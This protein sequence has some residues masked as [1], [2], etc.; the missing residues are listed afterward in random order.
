MLKPVT[1]ND[2]GN[3]WPQQSV[4]NDNNATGSSTGSAQPST[5]LGEPDRASI[6]LEAPLQTV[7]N[8]FL[9]SPQILS[10]STP[11]TG[12]SSPPS[13]N[14]EAMLATV[15]QDGLK[16]MSASK[17]LQGDRDLVL[18]AVRQNGLALQ[19]ASKELQS[20]KY[21]VLAAV[22]QN[23]S[24]LRHASRELQDDR[25]FNLSVVKQDGLALESVN[26]V[27]QNDREF[28]LIALQQNGLSL[29]FA[30]R[31][32]KSTRELVRIALLQNGLAL[33]FA[34][35]EL[36]KDRDLILVA[37]KQNGLA[38]QFAPEEFRAIYNL[39]YAAVT[40]NGLALQFA[41]TQLRCER[42]LVL[43]AVRQNGLALQ[44]S[45]KQLKS[46]REVV[47]VA[48]R[49][50][51]LALA[52][53]SSNLRVDEAILLEIIG[54]DLKAGVT[55]TANDPEVANRLALLQAEV[56]QETLKTTSRIAAVDA[57][58]RSAI[59]SIGELFDRQLKIIKALLAQLP[60]QRNFQTI[61]QRW[62][63]EI[64]EFRQEQIADYNSLIE[65][66]A[67]IVEDGIE[68]P[69]TE[70]KKEELKRNWRATL[71]KII[72]E[73]GPL[74]IDAQTN[75][76]ALKSHIERQRAVKFDSY[77]QMMDSKTSLTN[78][79]FQ[80]QHEA[81]QLFLI[82]QQWLQS[83]AR[84][85][86][87]ASATGNMGV[88]NQCLGTFWPWN[89]RA[90]VNQLNVKGFAPIHLAVSND[91]GAVLDLLLSNSADPCLP[92]S[93]KNQPLHWAAKKGLIPIAVKLLNAGGKINALGA[94]DRCPLHM[95]VFNGREEGRLDCQIEMTEFLLNHGASINA[96]VGPRDGSKTA[97]HDAVYFGLTNMVRCLVQRSELDVMICDR[98][99]LSPLYYAVMRGDLDIAALIVGHSSWKPVQDP[100]NPNHRDKLLQLRI[101]KNG[102]EMR[103]FLRT[104][105]I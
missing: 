22:K 37:V 61:E 42:E 39:V 31:E 28:I 100:Q 94:E 52:H 10:G 41:S 26:Q 57:V 79:L 62:E 71:N 98:N 16:L 105:A 36:Q 69:L 72:D 43:E 5:H 21:L 64:A 78:R 91:Q 53:A 59:A 4:N 77:N 92:D 74:E 102:D 82:R 11:V 84:D 103:L 15:R 93:N 17:E 90:G 97:L 99:G 56:E 89:R 83:Q 65:Q 20:D 38:L 34:D 95:A 2:G 73:V 35:R 54:R 14:K 76:E 86:W 55:P 12:N 44:Y 23:R 58:M 24:A 67:T 40:Q 8:P 49:Q 70:T 88:L 7:P 75:L 87:C 1:S 19:F 6:L 48:V 66:R 68:V 96:Q 25:E 32:I 3:Q 85:L 60:D 18:V 101:E 81:H 80:L 104:L 9:V 46:D 47:L 51:R 63:T 33:Q 30:N 50:N 29:Q 13:D 27:F 45:S